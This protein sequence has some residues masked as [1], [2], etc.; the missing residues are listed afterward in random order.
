MR[1]WRFH[2]KVWFAWGK[3]WAVQVVWLPEI[4]FGIRVEWRR[5][6]VD[7]FF[8]VATIAIGKHPLLS[9]PRY[10]HRHSDRGF[11]YDHALLED[12]PL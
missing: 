8:G 2:K 3:W 10:Q 1:T 6:L 11:L 12:A 9:D 7:I 5:P 4:S